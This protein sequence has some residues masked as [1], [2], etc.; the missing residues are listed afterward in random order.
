MQEGRDPI[1][2]VTGAVCDGLR[3]IGDFSYAVLPRE[4]AHKLGDFKKAVLTEL[5]NALQW[6]K[7]W[8]DNRVAGGDR[9][10]E[11]WREKCEREPSA[12]TTSG[13]VV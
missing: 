7:E 5:T 3:Q 12:N 11:K 9:L 2:D 13:P 6:E 10:R 8:I 1:R 4:I